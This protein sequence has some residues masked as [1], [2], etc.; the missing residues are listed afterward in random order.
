MILVLD[1]LNYNDIGYIEEDS[2]LEID[3]VIADVFG[4]GDEI[5]EVVDDSF[6]Q[7][8]LNDLEEIDK[9]EIEAKL[10]E[11]ISPKELLN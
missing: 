4:F 3:L 8:L 6:V 9:E 10:N 2:R 5:N 11:L 7:E 1:F